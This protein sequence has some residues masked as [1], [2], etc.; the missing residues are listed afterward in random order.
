MQYQV[1]QWE[2]TDEDH[3]NI[4]AH[5]WAGYVDYADVTFKP[6]KELMSRIRDKYKMVAL[7]EANDLNEVFHI[8]NVRPSGSIT[9]VGKMHS[10]SVGDIIRDEAGNEV[11][12]DS[13][14]F[15]KL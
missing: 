11:F 12:V 6:S 14:G 3:D 8:G 2:L 1:Y 13:F 10:I 15:G 4:N 5:G 9:Y 7:I